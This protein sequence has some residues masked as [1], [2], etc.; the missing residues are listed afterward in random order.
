MKETA[1]KLIR[2]VGDTAPRLEAISGREAARRPGVEKWSRKEILGHLID[3]A[4]NNHQRFVRG[5][6]AAR[7]DFPNYSQNEWNAAQ[8]YQEEP[9]DLLV[10]L[11]VAYN[12]HLAHV[13]AGI[14]PEAAAHLC[15]I[16]E[17]SPPVTL[18][19]LAED[20]IRHLLHHLAQIDALSRD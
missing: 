12:R 6:F 13:I 16:G 3:S 17:G 8:R 1:E 19:A 9:W 10:R 15:V 5:Q 11:W 2:I 14:T 18:G 4:S 20:Y 7:L